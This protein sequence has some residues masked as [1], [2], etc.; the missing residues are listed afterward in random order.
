[1][2]I[3]TP[4]GYRDVT[5][6]NVGDQVSA[7]DVSTGA[8]I[9]NTIETI[10]PVDAAEFASWQNPRV[11]V[12]GEQRFGAHTVRTTLGVKRVD[13]LAVGDAVRENGGEFQVFSVEVLD[14]VPTFDFYKING[15]WTLF[16][17]QSI[18]RN[19]TNVCHARDLIVGDV[20]HDDKDRDVTIASIEVVEDKSQIWYR[21]SIS[22]D[23]S[24]IIDGLTVHNASRFWVGGT[25]SFTPTNTTN[26]ASTSGGAGGQSVPGSADDTTWDSLSGGG[27]TT[28]NFGGSISLNSITNNAFTGTWDN[29][30]NNNNITL[31]LTGTAYNCS[32]SGVRTI[33]LG[34]ATYTMT[35]AALAQFGFNPATNLTLS[36][37][38]ATLS[39][40][41][42]GT[43]AITA[44]GSQT[45]GTVSFG[46]SSGVGFCHF[47]SSMTVGTLNVTAP[48]VVQFGAGSTVTISNPFAFTGS[49][50]SE[51][52]I[53][54][55]GF[56]TTAT[57]AAAA[58]STASWCAFRDMTFTGSPVASN[59]FDLLHNSGITITPP[60]SGG[61]GGGGS[62][63]SFSV[64]IF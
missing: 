54:S 40:A 23:H 27:T 8:A 11:L 33:K 48:N 17:E 9:L 56:P 14:K 20:I 46:T 36:A 43:K 38:A 45:F 18:W 29:S 52:S 4:S 6:C 22:G 64:T 28:L 49:P 51:I 63:P 21:F 41:G 26:W 47:V 12:N 61:G 35:A 42:A 5:T 3:L 7:F 59:S 19:G 16:R 37:S 34:S 15:T 60:S 31:S 39:F 62:G 32:G 25:G 24:Y 58:A 30:V 44:G 53:S 57:V 2:Q 13:A 1:M 55:D 10:Q 50:G